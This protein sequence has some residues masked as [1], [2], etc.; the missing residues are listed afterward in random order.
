MPVVGVAWERLGVE[1]ELA[2]WGAAIGGDDR[3][4]DAE[5]VRRG[6]LAFADAFDFR[7]VE[8]IEL[9]PALALL[10]RPDLLGIAARHHGGALGDAQIGLAQPHAMLFCQTYKACDRRM[11]ELGVGR[12]SDRLGLHGS[13]HR[14]P[15]E[16]ACA[17]RA[18]CVRDPQA[19]GQKQLELVAEPLA[20]MAQ[21][22]ALVRECVLEELRAG[23][24]LKIRVMDPALAHAFVG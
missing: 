19:L 23:E 14:D 1:H 12:E 10:L 16:V 13:V 24:M 9:P 7:C 6:G 20:P 17:Q 18:G 11:Q 3:C 22:G 2:A 4:L 8:R 21:V 5:L 15:F